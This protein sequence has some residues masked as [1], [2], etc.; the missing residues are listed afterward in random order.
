MRVGPDYWTHSGLKLGLSSVMTNKP[1]FCVE[2]EPRAGRVVGIAAK[3]QYFPTQSN[4][5]GGGRSCSCSD[6]RDL[7]IAGMMSYHM[8]ETE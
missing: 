1:Y 5:F 6:D 7:A 4:G 3:F 8:N 2:H